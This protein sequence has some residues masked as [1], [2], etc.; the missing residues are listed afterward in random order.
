[1]AEPSIFGPFR[2]LDLGNDLRFNPHPGTTGPTGGST[3]RD[4]SVEW[5]RLST[6]RLQSSQHV[7]QPGLIETG[8]DVA[9]VAQLAVFVVAAENERAQ[10]VGAAAGA[11]GVADD[12]KLV[13]TAGLDLEPG[14]DPFPRLV[15]AV[16]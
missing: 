5:T 11:A 8:A 15:D 13:G 14:S 9:G 2:V 1:M 7:V 10:G 16:A 12:D 6:Q 4:R 3:T